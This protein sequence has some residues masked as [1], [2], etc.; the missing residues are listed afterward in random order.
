[1]P[2]IELTLPELLDFMCWRLSSAKS[3]D[4]LALLAVAVALDL[5]SKSD[6]TLIPG[7]IDLLREAYKKRLDELKKLVDTPKEIG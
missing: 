5:A 7:A 3:Q 4:A 2:T 6:Y 1:M